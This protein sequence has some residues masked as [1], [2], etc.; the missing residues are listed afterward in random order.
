MSDRLLGSVYQKALRDQARAL[1]GWSL[2]ILG[3]LL[4]MLAV[5]PSVAAEADSFQKLL[6]SYPP[7]MR[8]FF[9]GFEEFTSPEG[10]FR[11][12]LTSS[13]FPVLFLVYAIGRAAD[14]L[15]G[16]E[17]RGDLELLLA[18]PVSRRRVALQKLAALAT[19]L[20]ALA[21]LAWLVL[22]VGDLAM[23]LDIGAGKLAL[24]FLLLFLLAAVFGGLAFGVGAAWGRKGLAVGVASGAAA[25]AF[26]LDG[27]ARLEDALEPLAL[28]S[29]WRHY[30]EAD[31]LVGTFEPWRGAL[32]LGLALGSALAGIWR[33]DRRDIAVG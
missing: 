31:A 6:E 18:H 28:L 32:L 13:F 1:L 33:F 15:A 8:A 30:A 26:L 23:G 3:I 22:V 25:A 20:A 24:A 7:A 21:T 2:G 9:G 12:E 10:F 11:T 19:G 27:L 17:E 16:E 14:L 29:P 4:M 5:Y